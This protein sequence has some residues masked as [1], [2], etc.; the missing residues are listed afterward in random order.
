MF[1][2]SFRK[3]LPSRLIILTSLISI[4]SRYHSTIGAETNASYPVI[5]HQFW[6]RVV[7][8]RANARVLLVLSR[9]VEIKVLLSGLKLTLLTQ[10]LC[11]FNVLN[12]TPFRTPQF[13]AFVDTGRSNSLTIWD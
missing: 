1:G 6:G 11:P 9:L 12:N 5:Y 3:I 13:Q 7:T 8:L 10:P 2:E 4:S